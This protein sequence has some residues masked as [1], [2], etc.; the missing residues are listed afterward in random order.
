MV[1]SSLRSYQIEGVEFLVDH[2]RALL[3][4]E[5]GLG[6]TVQVATALRELRAR[7]RLRRGLVVA[8]ASL[9]RNWQ[10]ELQ[11]WGP[12]VAVRTT[13]ALNE[14]DRL[15]TYEL[16]VPLIVTSYESLRRDF[17]VDP[18][19]VD[20]DVVVFD[21]AQRLKD[22][23]ADTTIA[24]R[25]V[26][27]KRRWLLSATPLENHIGDVISLLR[28]SGMN[29][30][31]AESTPDDVIELLQGNFLRRR[32]RDVLPQLPPII[33]QTIL[34]RLEGSQRREYDELESTLQLGGGSV[35]SYLAA[36]TRLK[37]ICNRAEDGTSA[38]LDLLQTILSDPGMETSRVIVVSQYVDTLRWLAGHL[39]GRANVYLLTGQD[40]AA[41]R[42][43]ALS[44]F[45]DGPAPALLLLSLK[46][47]GVGLN[48]PSASHVVLFDRWWNPAAEEQAI[49]RAHRFGRQ[50]P[51]LAYR[52]LVEDSVEDRID[53][54]LR[55]KSKLFAEVVDHG[56]STWDGDPVKLTKT[57][58]LEVLRVHH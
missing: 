3:A 50:E 31:S 11:T 48:I 24:A 51:L 43:R 15:A 57:E 58:L 49:H 20:F 55:R 45:I 19:Q 21:E 1:M 7:G 29:G 12:D 47:G 46:A 42:E 44:D 25:R 17:L 4:D 27:A 30:L 36:I 2:D 38:K 6:K 9:L 5:M 8:P 35:A 23:D 39:S 37:Q 40:G 28:A 26:R 22:A 41:E 14:D 52:F 53:S 13:E 54:I 33:D 16:P 34:V 10:A 32:K 18:P 56:A